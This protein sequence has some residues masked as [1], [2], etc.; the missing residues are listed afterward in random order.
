[1]KISAGTLIKYN[2]KLLFCHPTNS[3]WKGTYSPPK[4][5]LD[6]GESS[7][8]AALRETE[9]EV[10]IIILKDK[11][12]NISPIEIDYIKKDIITKRV[13]LY[14]VEI[15]SLEEIGLKSEVVPKDQLQLEE[16]DWAGFL[17]KEEIMEK[18]FHW[19]QKLTNL[20]N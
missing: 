12:S 10:G 19:F 6:K 1:M 16:I 5:G 3:A 4:G 20:L 13:I 2:N 15:N 7:L 18:C 17:S 14:L 9:E 11:I 8:D